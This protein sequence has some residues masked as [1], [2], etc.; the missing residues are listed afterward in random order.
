MK[1]NTSTFEESNLVVSKEDRIAYAHTLMGYYDS[2]VS[3]SGTSLSPDSEPVQTLVG[4]AYTLIRELKSYY[5]KAADT[6]FTAQEFAE[7][8]TELLQQ[9]E[10][11]LESY[12][13]TAFDFL[14]SAITHFG[15]YN[16]K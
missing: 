9:K 13:E 4:L 15:N 6:E 14:I 10:S 16:G 8:Q 12:G 11:L 5:H 2:I 1:I 3:L 7:Q